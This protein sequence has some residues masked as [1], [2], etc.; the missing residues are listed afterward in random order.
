MVENGGKLIVLFRLIQVKR[1]TMDIFA[2][3]SEIGSSIIGSLIF[4]KTNLLSISVCLL[5]VANV[6]VQ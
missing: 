2:L 1:K 5:E 4:L 3:E 6:C